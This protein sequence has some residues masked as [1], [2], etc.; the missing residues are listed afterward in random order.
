MVLRCQLPRHAT[1]CVRANPNRPQDGRSRPSLTDRSMTT[2]PNLPNRRGKPSKKASKF[3]VSSPSCGGAKGYSKRRPRLVTQTQQRRD[4][5]E[6][7]RIQL[8]PK[9]RTPSPVKLTT[10]VKFPP[11]N[12]VSRPEMKP[13]EKEKAC[14]AQ[15]WDGRPEPRLSSPCPGP[16]PGRVAVAHRSSAQASA[17]PD[18]TPRD[19][20]VLAISVSDISSLSRELSSLFFERVCLC[21]WFGLVCLPYSHARAI[22]TWV[23]LRHLHAVMDGVQTV[24]FKEGVLFTTG[25][26]WAAASPRRRVR[27]M[28]RSICVA[29]NKQTS[30]R[31]WNW[32]C[33][34]TRTSSAQIDRKTLPSPRRSSKT[35]RSAIH[36]KSK[37]LTH[38]NTHTHTPTTHLLQNEKKNQKEAHTTTHANI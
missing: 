5:D 36:N 2:V 33:T 32:V 35:Q 11:C 15:A 34:Q 21:V 8:L 28:M 25:S 27:L 26:P 7:E 14:R 12:A 30:R 29:T 13:H 38:A 24:L 23:P 31:G 10:R 22:S 1:T 19:I 3:Q 20:S 17:P 37:T 6:T 9:P 18:F 16:G 4:H